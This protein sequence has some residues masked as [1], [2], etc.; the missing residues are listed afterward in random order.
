MSDGV[1]ADSQF[2]AE[3]AAL[4]S[5]TATKVVV[6]MNVNTAMLASPRRSSDRKKVTR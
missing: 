5:G 6:R 1:R 4:Q 3:W 2:M